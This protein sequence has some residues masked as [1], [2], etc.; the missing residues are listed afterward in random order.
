MA[1]KKEEKRGIELRIPSLYIDLDLFEGKLDEIV[2][3]IK[4]LP[5]RLKEQVEKYH[6]PAQDL[7]QVEFYKLKHENNWDESMEIILKGYRWETD[8]EFEERIKKQKAADKKRKQTLAL[9]QKEKETEDRKLYE[10]LKKRFENV[11]DKEEKPD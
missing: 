7:D 6:Y 2:E 10:E 1:R 4:K 3:N 8:Q 11:Q 5:N 9:K